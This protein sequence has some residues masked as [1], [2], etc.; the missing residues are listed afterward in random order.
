MKG[1]ISELIGGKTIEPDI[2][3]FCIEIVRTA[4]GVRSE[5]LALFSPEL[6]LG[7]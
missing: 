2:P 3:T 4:I 1:V 5:K 7:A 6:G